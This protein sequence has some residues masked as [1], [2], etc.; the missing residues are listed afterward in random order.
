[1]QIVSWNNSEESV[2]LVYNVQIGAPE[3]K[4]Q[5]NK[6]KKNYQQSTVCMD[7]VHCTLYNVHV[8]N[9]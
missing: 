9:K 8:C 1:M 7:D 4:L 2:H 3:Y 5:T 6:I